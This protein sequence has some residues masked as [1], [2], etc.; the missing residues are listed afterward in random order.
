MLQFVLT[1]QYVRR[2]QQQRRFVVFN[3]LDADVR[4]RIGA[5]FV[6]KLIQQIRPRVTIVCSIVSGIISFAV[7]FY[8]RAPFSNQAILSEDVLLPIFVFT[9]IKLLFN[10]GVDDLFAFQAAR[11]SRPLEV[12]GN[13]MHDSLGQSIGDQGGYDLARSCHQIWIYL[14]KE[15]RDRSLCE[16]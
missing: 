2:H 11:Q 1:I 6:E 12:L 7:D 5:R 15:W 4:R 16:L 9:I 14:G 10:I 3:H 13:I 8:E